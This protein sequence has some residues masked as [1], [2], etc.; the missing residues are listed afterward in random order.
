M[1]SVGSRPGISRGPATTSR[2]PPRNRSAPQGPW[3]LSY[4]RW[5]LFLGGA[6]LF[7]GPFVAVSLL[8]G[9]HAVGAE[10]PAAALDL[11]ASF[12]R[13][14]LAYLL[15]L[16]FSLAYGY[17]AATR[18]SAERVLLPILDILQSVPILGFFPVAIVFFVGL[19]GPNSIIGPNFASIFLIFT[20]MS[21]NMTFGVYESIKTVPQD[22]REASDSFQLKGT[23]RL[24]RVLLPATANRLV[25]N[26]ILSWTAG[27]Y[28][29]VAAEFI[30]VSSSTTVLP[31]I[32]SFLLL[33]ASSGDT[34]ALVAGL[35]LLV[36]LIAA[37]DVFLWRPLSRWAERFRYDT[38][39]SGAADGMITRR[40]PPVPLRRAAGAVVRYVRTGV[41]RVGT[42]LLY[43]G[44][45]VPRPRRLQVSRSKLGSTFRTAA[46]GLIL[47]LVWLLLIALTVAIYHVYSAPIVPAVMAKI[48][49]LPLAFLFSF[50][51]VG[52][53]YLLSLAIALPVAIWI[54]S[55]PRTARVA[56]PVVEII[57]SVPATA[58]F[59]LFIF[60]LLPFIG[61]QGAAVLMIVTGMM[62]YLFFNILSGLRGIPPD[63]EEAARSLAL[64]KKV[65]YRRVLLPAIFPAFVTGSITAF[66]GGW[67]T[68]VIAEY[69]HYSA[70]QSLQV[71]GVGELINVGL[72]F[73]H[74]EGLPLM[75]SALLTLVI[76][77]VALNELLWKPM[78]RKAVEKYRV[79]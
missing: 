37:L 53:A 62:W 11:G 61:F 57:A 70:S 71:L 1:E 34:A 50:S 6:L 72:Y 28:F 48:Y 68:L 9:A 59:P 20:S 36:A 8:P 3:Y 24:R 12:L 74:N 10:L 46:L 14:L 69:L 2:N 35:L 65:Y 43:L 29:L 13:M 27:W 55:R 51:R 42:P 60:A 19:T 4:S 67:N 18:R 54:A 30:S 64:P 58:L 39:P 77:V 52:A 44:A 16:A 66:G 15:S 56:L 26:S 25:Y 45:L 40:G 47:V 7:G 73:P 75:V 63:L 49:T 79:D 78:Y 23:E 41:S 31:G 32:G 21:W 22:L 38:A 76:G 33:A 5:S 17:Y